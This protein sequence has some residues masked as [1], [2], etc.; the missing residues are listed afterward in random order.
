MCWWCVFKYECVR[1]SY[2][3]TSKTGYTHSRVL[4][5]DICSLKCCLLFTC[6][7][8][9][10][11]HCIS[12]FSAFLSAVFEIAQLTCYNSCTGDYSL[13]PSVSYFLLID[14]SLIYSS[15]LTLICWLPGIY[16]VLFTKRMWVKKVN[17][18]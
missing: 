17:K 4:Q 2:R 18:I 8:P 3:M 9:L 16:R 6:N 11:T 13:F 5:M 1:Y 12:A 14:K 10:N 15:V 7:L